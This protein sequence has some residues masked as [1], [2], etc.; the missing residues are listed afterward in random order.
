MIITVTQ[1]FTFLH[2]QDND[3]LDKFKV[4]LDAIDDGNWVGDYTSNSITYTH[5]QSYLERGKSDD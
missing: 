1:S 5:M 3:K 2:P 4:I